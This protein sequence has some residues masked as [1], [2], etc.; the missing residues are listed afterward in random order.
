M[1]SSAM[2][3]SSHARHGGWEGAAFVA[4]QDGPDAAEKGE[5]EAE[6]VTLKAAVGALFLRAVHPV[7]GK[8]RGATAAIR[9]LYHP[10]S[11]RPSPPQSRCNRPWSVAHR[12]RRSQKRN[13]HAREYDIGFRQSPLRHTYRTT[14]SSSLVSTSAPR[15]L[16]R[17]TKRPQH[18]RIQPQRA[19]S[20]PLFLAAAP[21]C[22]SSI[23]SCSF[24]LCPGSECPSRQ[25]QPEEEQ[26]I[27]DEV[28]SFF[29]DKMD[30]L[31]KENQENINLLTLEMTQ[32]IQVAVEVNEPEEELMIIQDEYVRKSMS[33]TI[34][35]TNKLINLLVEIG[36]YT[37][38]EA[39]ELAS[40]VEGFEEITDYP[41]ASWIIAHKQDEDGWLAN[42]LPQ[43]PGFFEARQSRCQ[44]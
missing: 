39:V 16:C 22:V 21:R 36:I 17:H 24:A 28:L 5:R 40:D 20:F 31:K 38:D 25:R 12:R 7:G 11:I 8:G 14:S 19:S 44:R 18:S 9:G 30:E 13:R 41:K 43:N 27:F 26:R 3:D 23:R 42:W 33:S 6:A 2:A 15:V 4:R 29:R 34:N 37:K 35:S 10:R 32:K 1:G